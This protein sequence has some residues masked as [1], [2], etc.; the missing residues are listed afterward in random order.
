MRTVRHSSLLIHHSVAPWTVRAALLSALVICL[1]LAALM[2][3]ERTSRAATP[4][5][6]PAA[7]GSYA[8]AP[9][10]PATPYDWL[11]FNGDPRHSGNNTLETTISAGNVAALTTLFQATLPSIADGAP[12]YLSG[13][14]TTSGTRD[15]LFLTTKAG[16]IVALDAHSGSQIWIQHNP[17]GSC[18]VNNRSQPCYT[19]SSPV[20]DPNRQFVYSYGLDG[21]VHKYQVGNG[22]EVTDGGWPEVATLKGFDEKGSSALAFATGKNGATYLYVANSGY[23]G[24][25]G[26]YQGHVTTINLSDGSQNVFNANCSDQAV[27]FGQSPNA[28]DCSAVQTAIWARPGV[29]YDPDTDRVYMATGNG[30][31]DPSQHNWGDTV[32]ALSPNGTGSTGSPLD[33][34]TPGNY[35]L[36]DDQDMD[37]GSTAPAILPA[38]A[39]SSV[40][41]L[42]VQGGKDGILRLLNLDNLSGQA[43]TGHTGGEISTT[44]VP[45]GGLVLP[46]PAVWV[47]PGDGSSWVFVVDD[48]GISGLKLTVDASGNPSL[49]PMWKNGPGGSSAIVANN[50]LYYASSGNVQALNPVDGTQLWTNTGIG[51][52]HWESPI[53]ANGILYIADENQHVTAYSL[54]R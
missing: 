5:G 52:I 35:Q 36:L 34:Y 53:V 43:G 26:N 31:F 27:H 38:P 48:S 8:V 10:G 20:V 42:A 3:A 12:A 39:N 22:T 29:V 19:T 7:T 13:V 41:H 11:Q 4:A 18:T 1:G 15:L 37:L 21:A 49:Q 28:P 24:D 16:D 6:R 17:A 30:S 44:R 32:F 50:V 33:S 47:N 23:L 25:R 51:G 14:S 46:Q 2:M 45:Q 40:Q 54:P 9:A